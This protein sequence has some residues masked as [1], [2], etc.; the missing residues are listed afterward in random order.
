MPVLTG[1][2]ARVTL[3][4]Y[5]YNSVSS[6]LTSAAAAPALAGRGS[7]LSVSAASLAVTGVLPLSRYPMFIS[8]PEEAVR[9]C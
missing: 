3:G 7:V 6:P 1:A 9:R 8:R 2:L 4:G 5:S